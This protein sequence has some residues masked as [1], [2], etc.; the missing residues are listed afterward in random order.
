MTR[1]TERWTWRRKAEILT[2]LD[3]GSV[4]PAD[5]LDLYGISAEELAAWQRDRERHG[6]RGLRTTQL[7]Y[8]RPERLR[9]RPPT[10][11]G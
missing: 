8:Y 5:I 1:F 11:K 10:K 7:H 9:P 4:T 6:D 3:N 2:A